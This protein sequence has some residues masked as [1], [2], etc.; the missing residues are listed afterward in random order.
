MIYFV[1]FFVLNENLVQ[2][3]RHYS[4]KFLLFSFDFCASISIFFACAQLYFYKNCT[5]GGSV[6]LSQQRDCHAGEQ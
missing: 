2:A 5:A 4:K 1:E 3:R 6:V